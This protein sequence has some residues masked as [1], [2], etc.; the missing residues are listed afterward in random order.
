M[1]IEGL[2]DVETGQIPGSGFDGNVHDHLHNGF[3]AG[4]TPRTPMGGTISGA[5][6]N[7]IEGHGAF[8]QRE[9]NH[10]TSSNPEV[11]M[12]ILTAVALLSSSTSFDVIRR[13]LSHSSPS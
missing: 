12:A 13:V 11:S 1:I 7:A 4:K 10:F 9:T 6:L 2:M 5:E 8:Y 3:S